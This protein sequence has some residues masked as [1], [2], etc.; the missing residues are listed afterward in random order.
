ML[1]AV[2]VLVVATVALFLVV[3]RRRGQLRRRRPAP[4]APAGHARRGRGD[5]AAPASR[6]GGQRRR[7]RGGGRRARRHRR[8]GRLDRRRATGRERRRVP[9][10]RASTCR[11]GWSSRAWRSPCSPRR[12]RRGGRPGRWR[13]SRPCWPCPAGRPDRRRPIAPPRSPRA[14]SSAA[15]SAWPSRATS[16]TT[17][18]DALDATSLLV[19]GRHD[20]HRPRRAARQPVRDPGAGR[21]A[22]RDCR[23][24]RGWRC[25]T[26]AGTRPAPAPPSP[27]SASRSGSPSPSSSPRPPPSTRRRPATCRTVSCLI[28]AADID[29]PFVPSRPTS[30]SLQA[31]VDRLVGIARRPDRDRPRRRRRPDCATRP[32]S[33]KDA[34]RSRSANGR[35]TDGAMCRRSTSPHR[36]SSTV[37][38]LDLDGSERRTSRSSPSRPA[39]WPSSDVERAPID[40]PRDGRARGRPPGLLLVAARIVHH[41]RRPPPTRAGR[42]SR[43]AGGSSRRAEPLTSDQLADRPRRRRGRRPDDRVP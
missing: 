16:S 4:P 2:S 20:G 42:R 9:D 13:A 36:S 41:P 1:A 30:P 22:R 19:V 37:Y 25:A 43:P 6:D 5:R 29:G 40:R 24:R 26:S 32:P 23:S 17:T 8:R 31:G 33:S 12:A 35:A 38:G 34:W 3:A 39:S 18:V 28:R 14:S 7:D 15:S 21:V 11:G 27:R 10:R